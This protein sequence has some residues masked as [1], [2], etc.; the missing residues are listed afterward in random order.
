MW[1]NFGD[2]IQFIQQEYCSFVV[3]FSR[4][5]SAAGALGLLARWFHEFQSTYSFSFKLRLKALY[6]RIRLQMYWTVVQI[7]QHLRWIMQ[8]VYPD[9]TLFRL[10]KAKSCKHRYPLCFHGFL[11]I[12][13]DSADM[14]V[15]SAR[16]AGACSVSC[17]MPNQ[18]HYCC[19]KPSCLFHDG[20]SVY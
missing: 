8:F 6:H 13:A 16:I 2:M 12:A 7:L 15:K 19:I 17:W 5:V 3:S 14:L 4:F 11:I 20:I 1:T 10:L 18:A 9:F